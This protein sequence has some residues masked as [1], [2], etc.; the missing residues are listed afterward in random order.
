[1]R[2]TLTKLLPKISDK[3][4]FARPEKLT[5][6]ETCPDTGNTY[7]REVKGYVIGLHAT[8]SKNIPVM[9][10]VRTC[11]DM[12]LP[13][14]ERSWQLDW[15]ESNLTRG[16]QGAIE[17]AFNERANMVSATEAGDW[18]RE[19]FKA[20]QGVMINRGTYFIPPEHTAELDKVAEVF[21]AID[22]AADE[23]A[24]FWLNEMPAA[25]GS[26]KTMKTLLR[27]FTKE[28]AD[29]CT[30]ADEKISTGEMGKRACKTQKADAEALIAKLED[31]RKLLGPS[32]D[33]LKKSIEDVTRDTAAFEMANFDL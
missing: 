24:T 11:T 32:V 20:S 22:G 33:K 27:W 18:A 15:V 12:S 25:A 14:H 30:K 21:E 13:V 31:W 26:Q 4:L 7:Q 5:V 19:V 10:R 17:M 6:E 9:A 23:D 28:I 8:G 3:K 16:T 1:L 2:E 29:F